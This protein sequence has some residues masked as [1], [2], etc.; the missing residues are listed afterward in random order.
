[1]ENLRGNDTSWGTGK[2]SLEIWIGGGGG[3]GGGKGSGQTLR[4]CYFNSVDVCRATI[5]LWWMRH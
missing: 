5:N 2:V 4:T 3:G 1:M